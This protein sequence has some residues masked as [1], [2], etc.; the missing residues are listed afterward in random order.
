MVGRRQQP[1]G[2]VAVIGLSADHDALVRGFLTAQGYTVLPA[3]GTLASPPHIADPEAVIVAGLASVTTPSTEAARRLRSEWFMWQPIVLLEA[4]PAPPLE[5]WAIWPAALGGPPRALEQALA[6]AAPLPFERRAEIVADALLALWEDIALLGPS[7]LSVLP[8]EI[9]ETADLA[10]RDPSVR[11]LPS[12]QP[13]LVLLDAVLSQGALSPD[14]NDLLQRLASRAETE[15]RESGASHALQSVLHRLAGQGALRGSRAKTDA[16]ASGALAAL[17]R[18]PLD[19]LAPLSPDLVA[20][21][22]ALQEEACSIPDAGA[23]GFLKL[24]RTEL[25]RL[26]EPLRQLRAAR[27]PHEVGPDISRILVIEDDEE[28]R[29]AIIQLL[30]G[31]ALPVAVCGAGTEAEARDLLSCAEPGG[32]TLALTNI[33]LPDNPDAG[34]ALIREFSGPGTSVRFV[35]LTAAANYADAVREAEQS[36][37]SAWDYVRK[38]SGHWMEELRSR[39]YAAMAPR[40]ARLPLV[41]VLRFTNRL[42]RVNGVEVEL[43]PKPFAVFEHL[44]ELPQRPR[45]LDATIDALTGPAAPEG[46]DLDDGGALEVTG[47]HIHEHITAIRRSVGAALKPTAYRI[48]PDI[49][50]ETWS[51]PQTEDEIEPTR[52]RAPNRATR[53]YIL[54][55]R[56]RL[57]DTERE[58]DLRA[59]PRSVLIVEDDPAWAGDVATTLGALGFRPRSAQTV[60]DAID[61]VGEEPPQLVVLDLQLPRD[62]AQLR[63]GITDEGNAVEFVDHL[64]ERC[65]DARVAVLSMIADQGDTMIEMLRRGVRLDDYISK[66]WDSPVQRLVHSVERLAREVERDAHIPHPAAPSALHKLAFRPGADNH[67]QLWVDDHEILFSGRQGALV[68]LLADARR[69]PVARSTIQDELWYPD[70]DDY[71]ENVDNALDQL[72]KNVRRKI[73]AAVG[74]DAGHHVIQSADGAYWMYGVME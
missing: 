51:G 22:R 11:G 29:Q 1:R 18:L 28:W 68:W 33:D 63:A 52:G 20:P 73:T 15:V 3:T 50:I 71:P 54:N 61:A 57:Y 56:A 58:L 60:A 21:L 66:R 19:L 69:L 42:V 10:A 8:A 31:L 59:P 4:R 16:R 36:G 17:R 43:G 9:A 25:A 74:G 30:E 35:I 55:A 72:V 14:D 12:M 5:D 64:R 24:C 62:G 44:A 65:P 26:A 46:R 34:R 40:R 41:E 13:L 38:T 2:S 47:S 45:L 37:I 48:D 32:G 70:E 7:S 53:G 39:I 27:R 23:E 67:V 49:L 6:Q